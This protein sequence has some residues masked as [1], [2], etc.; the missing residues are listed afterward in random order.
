MPQ[1]CRAARQRGK[2]LTK[3]C[4]YCLTDPS[5]G[6]I[7]GETRRYGLILTR[8]CSRFAQARSS[9]LSSLRQVPQSRRMSSQALVSDTFTLSGE[10]LERLRQVLKVA[11]HQ[12]H[13]AQSS[14]YGRHVEDVLAEIEETIGDHLVRIEHALDDDKAEAEDSGEAERIRRT[15]FSRYEA[16]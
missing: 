13:A 8:A 16:V 9:A 4:V 3:S 7:L 11:V 5:F 1:D 6:R 2:P 10:R 14:G 12:A 15:Y